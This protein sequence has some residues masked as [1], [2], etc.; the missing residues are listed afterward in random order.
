MERRRQQVL[1]RMMELGL[2]TRVIQTQDGM[3]DMVVNHTKSIEV[4]KSMSIHPYAARLPLKV[5]WN[6]MSLGKSIRTNVRK[7][8]I[9]EERVME[10]WT[11]LWM[12]LVLLPGVSLRQKRK[13]KVLMLRRKE[14]R[15]RHKLLLANE[16]RSLK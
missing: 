8:I 6:R 15:N 14:V 7:F 11:C 2:C 4:K 16:K 9:T 1:F 13:P 12:L 3:L 5:V 10:T